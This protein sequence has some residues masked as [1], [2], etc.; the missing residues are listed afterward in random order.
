MLMTKTSI[1]VYMLF[2][3]LGSINVYGVLFIIC[4]TDTDLY[5]FYIKKKSNLFLG[6]IDMYSIVCFH[7]SINMLILLLC[8]KFFHILCMKQ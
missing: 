5:D 8:S 6:W 4:N 1:D 3:L 7:L 2:T